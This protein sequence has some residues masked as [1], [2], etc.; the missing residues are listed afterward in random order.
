MNGDITHKLQR[1]LEKM[2]KLNLQLMMIILVQMSITGLAI[3]MMMM[4]IAN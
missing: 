2:E 4:E 1:Y 3:S